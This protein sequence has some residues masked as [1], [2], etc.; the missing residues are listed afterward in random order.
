MRNVFFFPSCESG[1][2]LA[3][4]PQRGC[5]LSIIADI[6]NPT[7]LGLEKPALTDFALSLGVVLNR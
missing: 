5:D 1:Q 7:G 4:V 3:R 6:Q 2:T